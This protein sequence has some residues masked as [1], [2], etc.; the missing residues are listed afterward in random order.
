M[1]QRPIPEAWRIAVSTA[2]KSGRFRY[3]ADARREW[4]NDFPFAFQFELEEAFVQALS[5]SN[6][7]GCHVT[8]AEPPGE[9]W[10]FYFTYE[11]TKT[12]GKILLRTEGQSAII[13]SAHRPQKGK[14][15]CE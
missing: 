14:L 9:T 1:S 3:T 12:Y 7:T 11:N 8:M 5:L 4:Q 6:L 2:L 13:L 15:S 10:E